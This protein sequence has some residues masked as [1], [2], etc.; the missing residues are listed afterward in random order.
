MKWLKK[1]LR[2][3]SAPRSVKRPEVV[4]DPASSPRPKPKSIPA[5]VNLLQEESYD[6]DVVG[7]S[8]YQD[9]LRSIVGAETDTGHEHIVDVWL[10]CEGKNPHDRNAVAVFVQEQ[11]VGYLPKSD[12]GEYRKELRELTGGIPPARTK[13]MIVGGGLRKRTGERLHLGIKL[14]LTIPPELD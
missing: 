7:E 11:K 3:S 5:T 12:S 8:N 6:F 9:A 10:I 1:I 14:D 4:A 2:L 13:G